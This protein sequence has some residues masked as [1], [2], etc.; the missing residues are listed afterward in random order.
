MDFMEILGDIYLFNV[1]VSQ[2]A[3]DLS[4]NYNFTSVFTT[5][6]LLQTLFFASLKYQL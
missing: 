3:D 6:N 5:V 4:L 1:F 2:M